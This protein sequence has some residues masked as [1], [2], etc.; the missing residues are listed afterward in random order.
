MSGLDE[1]WQDDVPQRSDRDADCAR[2]A[3]AMPG[4]E[5]ETWTP[6]GTKGFH[7]GRGTGNLT[8]VPFPAPDAPLGDRMR[9]VG[10]LAE[11]L[12]CRY[13]RVTQGPAG[14]LVNLSD[15]TGGEAYDLAHAAV[16]AA[17]ATR[18]GTNGTA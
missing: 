5:Y 18:G 7:V 15:D 1:Y 8:F 12:G 13:P 17:L 2:L 6:P 14:W 9:F 10:E 16:R 4:W 11:A 3:E